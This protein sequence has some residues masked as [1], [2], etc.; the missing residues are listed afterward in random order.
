M[1]GIRQQDYA[2]LIVSDL[3]LKSKNCMFE[4]TE[5]MKEQEYVDRIF[6]GVVEHGIYNP[7]KRVEYIEYWHRTVAYRRTSSLQELKKFM[8]VN[9][10]E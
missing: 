5:I 10:D 1:K 4:V 3:Y 7:L 6:P 2:V 9:A 8:E